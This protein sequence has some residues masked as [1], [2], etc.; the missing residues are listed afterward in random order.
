MKI[1]HFFALKQR[2]EC[3]SQQVSPCDSQPSGKAMVWIDS[4]R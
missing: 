1:D 2:R 3:R 4:A